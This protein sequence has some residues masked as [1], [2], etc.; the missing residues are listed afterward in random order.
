[1]KKVRVNSTNEE[2][3]PTNEDYNP[4]IAGCN[5]TNEVHDSTTAIFVPLK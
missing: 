4:T 2:Y 3:D 1:M 5:P